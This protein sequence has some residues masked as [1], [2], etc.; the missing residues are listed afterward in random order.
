MKLLIPKRK[1]LEFVVIMH[2]DVFKL[3]PDNKT[4]EDVI[5]GDLYLDLNKDGDLVCDVEFE[6]RP[7]LS[8]LSAP[9][10]LIS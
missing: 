2:R 10:H 3:T 6:L 1:F 5:F 4:T 9:Q 8:T 7:R